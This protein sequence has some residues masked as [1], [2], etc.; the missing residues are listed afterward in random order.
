MYVTEY[1]TKCYGVTF[2]INGW[3]KVQ[4]FEDIS[5]DKNTMYCVKPL[6]ISLG[7]SESCL[8]TALSGSFNK[9]VFNGNTILL[10]ISEENDNHRYLSLRGDMVCS[11]LTNDKIYKHI[12]TMGNNLIPY[13][14]A[15]GE[16]NIYFLTPHFE[17]N[18]KENIKNIELMETNEN[19]VD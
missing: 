4:K 8:M 16:E 1:N 11:F 6:D 5:D 12:L 13:S 14:I 17:Y 19:F 18:K 10:R 9:K 2:H 7:K 3:I 15:I